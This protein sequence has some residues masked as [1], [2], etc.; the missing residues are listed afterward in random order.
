[1]RASLR[2]AVRR[3]P[4]VARRD[5]RIN[6]LRQRVATLRNQAALLEQLLAAATESVQ[7][8]SFRRLILLERRLGDLAVEL[9]RPWTSVG[10]LGKLT[11]YAVAASHG[12]D[13]PRQLGRWDDPVDIP[14]DD[15]PDRVVVKSAFGS[16]SRGVFPLE[17]VS[18]GW[19]VITHDEIV[20][21]AQIVAR[22]MSLADRGRER[23]PYFA[24]EFLDNG[25]GVPPSDT[26]VWSFYGEAGLVALRRTTQHGSSAHT[27]Y[28]FITPDGRDAIERHPTLPTDP[29]IPAP[30]VLEEIMRTADR[31]SVVLREPCLR[32]D[33]YQVGEHVVLGEVTRRPGGTQWHGPAL[34][35]LLGE[36]WERAKARLARD[37][38]D[39]MSPELEWGPVAVERQE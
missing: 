20:T 30:T 17:R 37:L 15:L 34:D 18:A 9:G 32:V 38:A 26:R 16:S 23:G 4:P 19:R 8:P 29:L 25:S 33:L 10:P 36:L 7:Q 22:L 27:Q 21:G 35:L 2:S 39:G 28:R 12:I 24:E 5:A 1:M 6:R 11:D 14:W 3:L 13:V 31:L